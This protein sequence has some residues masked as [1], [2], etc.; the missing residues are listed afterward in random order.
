[1]CKSL[2]EY[3]IDPNLCTGCGACTRVCPQMSITGEKKAPHIVN[4]MQ[5]I[6]CGA[7]YD[8]CRFDAILVRSGDVQPALAATETN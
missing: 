4:K 8:V 7:C 2:I 6:K 3:W 5:C 1:M